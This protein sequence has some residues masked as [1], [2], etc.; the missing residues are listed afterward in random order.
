MTFARIQSPIVFSYH[1]GKTYIL[2]LK[3]CIMDFSFILSN[4]LDPRPHIEYVCYKAYTTP[5]FVLRL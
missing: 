3:L 2:R 4:S 1:I 5:R